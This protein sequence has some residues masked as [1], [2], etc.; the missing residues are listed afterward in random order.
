MLIITSYSYPLTTF[1]SISFNTFRD[2]SR[3]ASFRIPWTKTT[4][5]EG[6]SIIVT[7]R[8]D[9]LCPCVALRNHLE[10]NPDVPCTSPLFA[11]T[12]TTG[13]WEHM[14]KH[15]FLDFCANV[16]LEA[17]LAHVLGHSF[18][19]GGAVELLLAGVPPEIVAATGGWTSLAFL[20]YWRRMEEILPM[21]TSKAYQRSH[22]DALAMIFEKFR[23]TCN[24][25][26]NFVALHD[27]VDDL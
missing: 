20:L 10:T 5:E 12:T 11:Y 8:S 16:W 1:C 6:A 18:R 2:G 14:T 21:C 23:V 25:P 7:A 17:A 26:M 24:I 3:S 13:Q 22:L 27:I 9:K 19:I 15:R 4:R